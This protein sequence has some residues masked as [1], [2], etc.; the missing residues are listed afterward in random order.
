MLNFDARSGELKLDERFRDAGSQKPGVSMD[1]KTWPHGF[2]GDAYAHGTV[3]SRPGGGK[4][5]SKSGE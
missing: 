4:N 1:G 5:A 3:F 2:Q